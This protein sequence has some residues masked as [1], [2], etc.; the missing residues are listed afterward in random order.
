[1]A[2]IETSLPYAWQ[3]I[4]DLTERLRASG[5]PVADNQLPPA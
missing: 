1:V 2:C 4:R 5:G 3:V